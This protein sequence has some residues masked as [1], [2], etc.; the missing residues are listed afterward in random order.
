[1]RDIPYDEVQDSLMRLLHCSFQV[2]GAK[3]IRSEYSSNHFS[4]A[5]KTLVTIIFKAGKGKPKASL[6]RGNTLPEKF[7][8]R[9]SKLIYSGLKESIFGEIME[10]HFASSLSKMYNFVP[11]CFEEMLKVLEKGFPLLSQELRILLNAQHS[12][13]EENKDQ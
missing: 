8:K 10:T 12:L 9:Y 6:F 4:N 11:I 13:F 1:M 2:K 3:V 7:L 5:L